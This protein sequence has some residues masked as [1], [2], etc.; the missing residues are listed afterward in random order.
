MSETMNPRAT[1]WQT[2]GPFFQ[3]G[4]ERLYQTNIAGV[5]VGGQ[6]LRLEGRILDGDGRP[7]PDAVVEVWQANS[8]GKYA[9]PADTQDK[10]L[11]QGF[12]GFGRIPTDDDGYF[13]LSTIKPGSVPGPNGTPQAPHLVVGLMMRGLLRGLITRAYFQG[14]PSNATDPVLQCVDSDRLDTLMMRPSSDDPT[15][16]QWTIRMQGE[17]E[18]VFFQI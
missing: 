16:L 18:T 1:T 15:L 6:R 5:G 12:K 9:H 3:I 4:L 11:E 8:Q 14:D 2:I 7:I 10:P 17:K 13:R